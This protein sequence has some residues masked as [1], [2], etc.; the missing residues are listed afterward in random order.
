MT[1]CF[2]VKSFDDMYCSAVESNISVKLIV[3]KNF[4]FCEHSLLIY[5]RLYDFTSYPT[6]KYVGTKIQITNQNA[7]PLT[8]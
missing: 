4:T 5:L 7:Y 6:N 8:S 2:W 1:F 3:N